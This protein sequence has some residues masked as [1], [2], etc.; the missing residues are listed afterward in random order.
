MLVWRNTARVWGVALAATS[1]A[2]A[3]PAQAQRGLERVLGGIRLNTTSRNVLAKYGNPTQVVVGEVGFRIPG[4]RPVPSAFAAGA[5]DPGGVPGGIAPYPAGPEGAAPGSPFGGV[6]GFPGAPGGPGGPGMPGAEGEPG[7]FGQPGANVGP[8]GN[9]FSKL[10]RSQE[11]TWIYDRP[12]GISYEFVIGPEGRVVQIKAI[13]YGRQANTSTARGIKLGS[14]YAQVV[15]KYGY[16]EEYQQVGPILV[17]SYRNKAHA[18][19][20]FMNSKV[21]AITI[22]TVE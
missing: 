6:G 1:L 19:F 2:L 21:I 9:T 20:Q 5:G 4:T 8:F 17:A 11:V 3:V 15:Q 14:T 18:S 13:G 10:A 12:G 7:G 22:S 16:A